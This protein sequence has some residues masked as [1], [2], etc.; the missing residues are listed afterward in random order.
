MKTFK[1]TSEREFHII[2]FID[3]SL[4]TYTPDSNIGKKGLLVKGVNVKDSNKKDVYIGLTDG[5][6]IKTLTNDDYDIYYISS[7][8][9]YI[10]NRY[11][12]I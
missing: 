3:K 12:D 4:V 10:Q 7:N 6:T 11:A 9:V 1:E 2:N 5:L 8:S